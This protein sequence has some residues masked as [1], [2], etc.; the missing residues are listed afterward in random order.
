[1]KNVFRKSSTLFIILFVSILYFACSKKRIEDP[2]VNQYNPVSTYLD[3]K[4]QAEQEFI[5]D[6]S[7]TGPI[8]GNQGT[9]ISIA[10]QCLMYPNGDS[11]TWPFTVKLVE[12]Y[13]PKDMIYYQMPTVASGN[14]LETGGEIRLGAFKNGTEL[15]LKPTPCFSQIE[16]PSTAP[17]N[18]MRVF[19]GFDSNGRPNWTDNPAS[20]GV[21]TSLSP[22]FSTTASSYIA[23]I[24]RL[25]WINCDV[26]VTNTPGSTLTFVSSTDNLTNVGLF[27]YLPATKTVMQVYNVTSDLI[28]NGVSATIIAI[29]VDA[30][31]QL[32]S[33]HTTQTI[34]GNAQVDVVLGPVTDADLTAFLDGL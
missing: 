2:T 9:K 29:A 7:N 17:K 14:I 11:V 3:T 24:A 16:M 15:V 13:K 20:L 27:I 25:G 12:L 10:K 4:K 6:S 19:Y 21:T 28:P 30:N 23:S 1:M 26:L 22:V 5:I 33:S 8:V 18:N 31:G 34:N 32:F